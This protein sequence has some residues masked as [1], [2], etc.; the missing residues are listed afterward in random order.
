MFSRCS[1][2]LESDG[3]P[4]RVRTALAL[5]NQVL[6]ETLAEQEG[7]M[8]ADTRWALTWF[9]Q[10]GFAEGPFG[11]ANTLANAKNT[12]AEGLVEARPRERGRSGACRYVRR[13]PQQDDGRGREEQ[14]LRDERSP[15]PART[16][17]VGRCV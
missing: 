2:V 3:S 8:D 17:T 14:C 4:M 11:D 13:R 7:E 12:S 15:H 9:D 16:V 10:Y 6:A 1:R 5:I